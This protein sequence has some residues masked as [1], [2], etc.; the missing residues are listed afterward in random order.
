MGFKGNELGIRSVLLNLSGKSINGKVR[1]G[2]HCELS[3][4]SISLQIPI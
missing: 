3:E 2:W 4:V 1:E